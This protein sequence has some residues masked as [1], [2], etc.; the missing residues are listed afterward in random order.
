MLT[1]HLLEGSRHKLQGTTKEEEEEEEER[2]DS[3]W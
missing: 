1:T 2:M 3:L